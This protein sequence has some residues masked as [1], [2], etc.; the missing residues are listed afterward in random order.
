VQPLYTAE[1]TDSAYQLNWS[2]SLFGKTALPSQ[3][4]W[5]QDL[6]VA[7]EPDGV[8]LLS[9]VNRSDNVIQ[10]LVS[11]KPQSSPSD[12]VQ[13]VKGRLQYLIRDQIPSAF[14][15]NYY[16]SSVGDA[17]STVL[18]QYV[19]GQTEKHPMAAPNV[20][21]RIAG[22]QF[23]DASIDLSKP[24][25]GTYGQYLNSLQMV[26]ENAEGWHDV[27]EDRLS[28]VRQIIVA[29]AKKKSWRLSRIGLLSN[30][31]HILLGAGVTEPPQSIALSLMN[32]IAYVYEMK[33][34]LKYSFYAGTFGSY[35]RGV[36]WQNQ[37]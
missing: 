24:M 13:S 32:N 21:S 25:I 9:A 5:L 18:D 37:S 28:R 15:R 12:I 33:P 27:S 6:S 35:D 31:I 29:S 3:E 10:F 2:L 30:H 11:T 34:I 7:T 26:F 19:A 23:C 36:I 16:I 1:N 8:R 17:K 20:Q 14:R 22:M 4:N